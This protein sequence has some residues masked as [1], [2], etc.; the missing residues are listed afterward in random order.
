VSRK[1]FE[2]FL[3]SMYKCFPVQ[4]MEERA[5]CIVCDAVKAGAARGSRV[6]GELWH[7]AARTEVCSGRWKLDIVIVLE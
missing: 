4:M 3:K 7:Q 6:G 5:C 2:I 1:N